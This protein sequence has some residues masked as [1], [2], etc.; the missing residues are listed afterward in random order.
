M[1]ETIREYGLE[2][3]AANEKLEVTRA[4]HGNY[5]LRHSEGVDSTPGE[6]EQAVWL[7]RLEREHGNLRAAM[8]FS[9]ERGEAGQDMEDGGEMALRFGVVLRNFWIIHGHWSEGRNFLERALAVSDGTVSVMRAKVLEPAPSIA[10]YQIDYNRATPLCP[11]SL[12][13]C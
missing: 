2:A 7:E 9:L 5:Y 4:A 13:Q 3:L 12:P 1:L 10:I 6:P 11:A 8:R